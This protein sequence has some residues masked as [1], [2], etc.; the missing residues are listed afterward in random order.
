MPPGTL[1]PPAPPL[2]SGTK[3]SPLVFVLSFLQAWLPM[4]QCPAQPLLSHALRLLPLL[5]V[6]GM[7]A[8]GDAAVSGP[9]STAGDDDEPRSG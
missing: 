8:T 9:A 2:F 5:S 7:D 1:Q 6:A 3:P 4:R